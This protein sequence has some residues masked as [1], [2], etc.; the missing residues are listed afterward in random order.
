MASP[1]SFKFTPLYGVMGRSPLCYV[2]QVR[3]P[4]PGT[5]GAGAPGVSCM[6]GVGQSAAMP[7]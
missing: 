5:Q 7:R 3:P 4:P 1:Q 6:G 2:L